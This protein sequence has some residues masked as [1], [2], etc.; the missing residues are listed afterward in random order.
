M[1][2]EG[3]NFEGDFTGY[4]ESLPAGYEDAQTTTLRE[5]FADHVGD[6]NNYMFGVVE[7]KDRVTLVQVAHGGVEQRVGPGPTRRSDDLQNTVAVRCFGKVGEHERVLGG[8]ALSR[9]Q[10]QAGLADSPGSPN[11]DHALIADELVEHGQ[12]I[13][14]ADVRGYGHRAVRPTPIAEIFQVKCF[15]RSLLRIRQPGRR[16]EARSIGMGRP[17]RRRNP[18]RFRL[19]VGA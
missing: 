3:R 6:G 1:Q 10:C 8:Q 18:E 2:P 14:T 4:V 13:D 11:R 7:E 15:D 12:L 9:G 16:R 19:T 17:K 5:K